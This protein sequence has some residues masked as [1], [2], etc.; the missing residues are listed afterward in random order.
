MKIDI[1]EVVA[2]VMKTTEL[3]DFVSINLFQLAK[4][5]EDF[6]LIFN[7]EVKYFSDM[8]EVNIKEIDYARLKEQIIERINQ[9][10][11]R[12]KKLVPYYRRDIPSLL[13][14]GNLIEWLGNGSKSTEYSKVPMRVIALA[15]YYKFKASEGEGITEKNCKNIA[16]KYGH[17]SDTS[18]R[19]LKNDHYNKILD[20]RERVGNI[21]T[22]KSKNKKRQDIS[23][24][25][26]LL[27]N[28][29]DA[30]AFANNDLSALIK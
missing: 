1:N 8:Y 21:D 27:T 3:R 10:I 30:I 9:L 22:E 19:K 16:I 17:K 12:H 4:S 23:S 15:E 14:A 18:G 5:S 11:E 20:D 6:K 29:P 24:A 28:S 13:A 25:I 2:D 7:R 26:T